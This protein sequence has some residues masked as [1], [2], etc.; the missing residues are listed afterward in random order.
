MKPKILFLCTHNSARSQLAEGIMRH[1]AGDRF[2]VYSA[3][4]VVT[5]VNPN[6]VKALSE[7]GIEIKGQYS[8]HVDDLKAIEFDYIVT[9]CDRAKSACPALPGK[10]QKI[11]WGLKDPGEVAG[12]EE[13]ILNAFKET[14]DLLFGLIKEEFEL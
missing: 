14:R 8:K 2:K 3:G 12:S 4:T 1:L 7:K 5:G 9:V 13:E 11:H 10:G 6:V